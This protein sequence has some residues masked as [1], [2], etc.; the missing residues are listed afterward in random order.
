MH[1]WGPRESSHVETLGAVAAASGGTLATAGSPANTKGAWAT[2][3]TT[4]ASWQAMHVMV[5]LGSA[6]ADHVFDIGIDLGGGTWRVI[7]PELRYPTLRAAAS[8]SQPFMLPLHVPAGSTLGWR[9]QATTA[10][11]TARLVLMGVETSFAGTPG[12]ARMTAHYTV[13]NS[14]GV[15]VDP[16][17]TA[18]T[19]GAWTQ[20]TGSTPAALDALLIGI[21][22]AGSLSRGTN[23]SWL[24]DIGVGAAGSE[25]IVLAN[26]L[27]TSANSLN[28]PATEVLGPIPCAIPEGSRLAVR[29]QCSLTDSAA[30][31]LDVALWGFDG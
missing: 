9:H 10:G 3:G 19:K 13:A 17:G 22:P 14:R 21:G 27:V 30:R 20:I 18:N 7:A 23:M 28:L 11:A 26:I 16:G 8:H 5:T 25:Q 1:G 12:F 6:A 31:V 15:T 29:G 4:S 24:L 2:L